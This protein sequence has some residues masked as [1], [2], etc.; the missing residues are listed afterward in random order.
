MLIGS[1]NVALALLPVPALSQQLP[2]EQA[3]TETAEELGPPSANTETNIDANIDGGAKPKAPKANILIAPVPF[4]SPATGTGL[5]GG[6]IAFYNPNN[7]PQQ[8]ISGGGIVWTDRGSRGI[9]AFHSMALQDD[10]IRIQGKISYMNEVTKFYGIGQ[11]DG[12]RGDVLELRSK[13]PTVQVTGQL[14]VF[15]HGYAGL[16]VR[17][18]G[19]D[20]NPKGESPT[21]PPRPDQ[22]DST[23]ST[24]GPGFA[25]DTRDS[26]TQPH[27]GVNFNAFW[28]FGRPTWG[29]SFKHD[30]LT[31]SGSFYTPAGKDTVFAV[32]GTLCGAGG[33]VPYYDLCL[34][35]SNSALRGYPSGRY[36]DQ[37]SW[38]A[39]AEVRHEFAKRWGGVAFFGLGGI[40]S[41]LGDLP[42]DSNL[43]PAAGVGVRYRP[44]KDN[45]VNLRVDVAVGKNDTGLYLSVGEAF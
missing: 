45:D 15:P 13:S 35:G 27:R 10:R 11:D 33:D 24:F 31:V 3:A 39:Q 21:L 38:S 16:R 5:A 42:S 29:D 32:N 28:L 8:W 9:A 43:L 30:K 19:V 14:R 1:A 37:A 44:F 41:S 34:F 40:A 12:D 26:S 17:V 22:L 36:R 7:S 18:M 25:Y 23:M 6:V 4:S 20:A 2:G